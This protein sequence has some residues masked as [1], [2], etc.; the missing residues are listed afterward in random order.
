MNA[1]RVRRANDPL[2]S[3][4]RYPQSVDG[5]HE[6]RLETGIDSA[7]SGRFRKHKGG[8]TVAFGA[9]TLLGR[10]T[11]PADGTQVTFPPELASETAVTVEDERGKGPR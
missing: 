5:Q 7:A 2:V 11:I 3:T 4:G 9:P 10:E 6:H 1:S 8:G